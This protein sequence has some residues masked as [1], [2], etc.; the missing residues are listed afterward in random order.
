MLNR[1][2][3]SLVLLVTLQACGQAPSKTKNITLQTFEKEF[4]KKKDIYLIDLR[5]PDEIIRGKIGSA[6]EMDYLNENFK[7]S[8]AKLDTNKTVVLYCASGGRSSRAA[9]ELIGMGFKNVYNLL[10]GYNEYSKKYGR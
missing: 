10:G 1:I 2:L 7:N 4:S 3:L 9:E 6:L 8:V 5:R